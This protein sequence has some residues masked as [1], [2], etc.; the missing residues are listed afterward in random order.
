MSR[1]AIGGEESIQDLRQ[2]TRLLAEGNTLVETGIYASLVT[3]FDATKESC[4]YYDNKYRGLTAVTKQLPTNTV[5]ELLLVE[6][7]CHTLG[8]VL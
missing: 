4:G 8:I 6:L 3:T 5:N 2:T 1:Q 7:V